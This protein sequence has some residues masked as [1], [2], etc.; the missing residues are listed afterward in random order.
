MSDARGPEAEQFFQ[1]MALHKYFLNADFLR[2]VFMRQIKDSGP[3]VDA[4]F[5]K[6]LNT[7]TA[8]SLWYATV[9]VVI[10]GWQELKLADA[11]VDACLTDENH[12]NHLRLFRNQMFHYQEAYDNPKLIKF[13]GEND[14]D[15]ETVTRWIRTTHAAL[16]E[17]IEAAIQANLDGQRRPDTRVENTNQ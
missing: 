11:K 15:A 14:S 12:V 6:S 2:D 17:A 10:E 16:G 5:A 3:P 1:L 4:S 7:M 9:F 8:M 13:L